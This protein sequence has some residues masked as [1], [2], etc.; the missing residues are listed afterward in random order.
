MQSIGSIISLPNLV[1]R[2]SELAG[3]INK[4]PLQELAHCFPLIV[5]HILGINS[6]IG[7]NLREL[8]KQNAP[9]E[10][11][12][13]LKLL[14]PTGPLLQLAYRL[15]T[16]PNLRYEFLLAHIPVSRIEYLNKK[17]CLNSN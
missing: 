6:N 3:F 4:T 17:L 15:M 1:Q 10:T 9:K 2:C 5:D 7:W 14:G 13:L 8:T 16:D 12:A 11:D